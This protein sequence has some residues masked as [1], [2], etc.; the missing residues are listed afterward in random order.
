MYDALDALTVSSC[1]SS[2]CAAPVRKDAATLPTWL[3]PWSSSLSSSSTAA[4]AVGT[5]TY[6]EPTAAWALCNG[7]Q[8]DERGKEAASLPASLASALTCVTGSHGGVAYVVR[9][10]RMSFETE[11]THEAIERVL[12]SVFADFDAAVNEWSASS[13]VSALN[14]DDESA[15]PSTRAVSES[16]AAVLEVCDEA[17]RASGGRFDA[18]VGSLTA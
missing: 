2:P 6:A 12:A 13:E 8:E 11:G 15:A 18:T 7:K 14:D 16:L 3:W 17:H 10:G 1:C 9:V 4:D 5:A